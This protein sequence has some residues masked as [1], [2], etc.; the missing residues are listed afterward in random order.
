MKKLSPEIGELM[1]EDPICI[2][3]EYVSQVRAFGSLGYTPDRIASI[4]P[5]TSHQRLALI[6]RINTKNDVYSDAF[7]NGH[8]IGE[9]NIDAELAKKAEKGDVD[10]ITLLE[11]RKNDRTEL[12]LRHDLF[13]V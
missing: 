4:L 11:Q 1:F 6:A 8:A 13:G 3:D 9:Y 7:Q 12:D 10:A 2:G 5:L